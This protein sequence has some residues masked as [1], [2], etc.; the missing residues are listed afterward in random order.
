MARQDEVIKT[1]SNGHEDVSDQDVSS[2]RR[3]DP[4]LRTLG[5]ILRQIEELDEPARG[6][7]MAYLCSRYQQGKE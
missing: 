6:R 3:M 2:G 4:E 7:V 1:E 5:A